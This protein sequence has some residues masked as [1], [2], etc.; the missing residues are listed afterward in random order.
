MLTLALL[1]EACGQAVN[2][3]WDWE[4]ATPESQGMSSI[5]L[6]ALKNNMAAHKTRA[7]LVVRNDKIVCEW[8]A[9]G[10]SNATK[11]G[12]ASMA[13]AI[14]GGLSL[15]VALTDG[16][17]NLDDPAAKFITQWQSDANKSRILIRHLGSHTSGLDDAE[18]DDL[19]HETLT[20]WKGDFWKR[21]DPPNDPFSIARDKTPFISTPG[22]KMNYS[23]PGIGLLSYCVTAS[24]RGTEYKDI[25]SLLRERVMQQIGVRDLDWSC[26]YAKTFTVDNLPL[27]ASWGGGAYTPRSVARIGR[28]I[29][30]EGDWEGKRIL[31]RKSVREVTTDAGLPGNCGMGW[32][33]NGGHRYSGLPE[34]AVWGAGA[35][36]QLL[37]VIQSLK[38]IMVRNGQTMEPGAGEP[39]V[40]QDNVFTR[41]HDFRERI[42][43]EPLVEAITNRPVKKAAAP[44]PPSAV[45][46]EIHWVAKEKIIRRAEGSDTWPL[47]W[48]DDDLLYTAYGDGNGFEP[49]VPEKLSMGLA[50][51]SGQ[52]P[53]FKGENLRAPSVE[54]KGAGAAGR[55]A[56]G[57]LMVENHLF[58]WTRNATNSQLGWSDDHGKTWTWSSWKFTNSFG[59]PTFL[60]FGK[61]YAGARDDLV[62]IYSHDNNSAYQPSD[63]MVLARVDRKRLRERE[64]YEFFQKL[65]T[66]GQPVWTKD[67]QERGAV[68][69]N[70]GKCYRSAISYNAGLKRYL[71]TQIIP[72]TEGKKP[73]TRFEGG[74][75]IYDAPEPWGPWTTVFLTDKWDVGPG[76]SSSFP[77]KWMSADGKILHLVFSSGD[78]FSVR[79]ATLITAPQPGTLTK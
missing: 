49:F 65:N 35:G 21:L 2:P 20:G 43:F 77:T 68:F 3:S 42:L 6:D 78:S 40:R 64:A 29:L 12:T 16:R 36:D 51:V 8:Y 17:I 47:T 28:L 30:R 71:W 9:P 13:K 33:S 32:W 1:H 18:S 57:I 56:S 27:V 62:Y 73:D 58:L 4:T 26:G 45:I 79:Q 60:N 76:E 70:P 52:P 23:N 50:T 55:K 7:L 61:N 34:D 48:G 44:Y 75:G 74:F 24:I 22:E 54:F 41:Y 72:G 59:C 15:A 5:K 11:Q 25:R 46:Q 38:L 39:P 63:R 69:S 37:L 53:Y 66:D 19:P 14:V 31:S 10:N 67:I